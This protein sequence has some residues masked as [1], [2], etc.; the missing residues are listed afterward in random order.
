[1]TLFIVGLALFFGIHLVP[2]LPAL[3]AR[4]AGAVGEERYK[5]TFSLVAAA[6]L[7]LT[8]VGYAIAPPGAPLFTPSPTAKSA[9]PLAMVV[10]FV[11]LASANMRTHI[12]ARL[13]HPMLLGIIIWS[14]VHLLANGDA[15]GALLFGAFLCYAVIDL[16]SALGRG[17]VK[18][19]V[20]TAR[21]DLMA[22]VGGVLAAVVVMWLHRMLFG[23]PAVPWS[24]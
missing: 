22:V 10:S 24:L 12:R 23:V 2:T 14:T 21:H 19:V 18:P 16:A 9:A 3:R 20:P 7:V 8:V 6:G 15:K 1:M 5:R 11:L 4:W 17:A 13:R